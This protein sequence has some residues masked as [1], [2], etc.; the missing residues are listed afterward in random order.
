[1]FR[2]VIRRLLGAVVVVWVVSVLTFAIFQLGPKLAKTSPIY[3]YVGKQPPPPGSPQYKLL[4]HAYGFDRPIPA[5]YWLWLKNIFHAHN[6]TDGTSPE[7]C[8]VP[9]L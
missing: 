9:C 2:Y 5:Q 4:L 7:P 8:A 3:F 1:M 6:L